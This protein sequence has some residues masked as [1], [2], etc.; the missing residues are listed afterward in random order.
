[1]SGC[2]ALDLLPRNDDELI[3]RVARAPLPEPAEEAG[4]LPRG[5]VARVR[6]L[7]NRVPAEAVERPD[8]TTEVRRARL[9]RP[10]ELGSI[11]NTVHAVARIAGTDFPLT[12][13]TFL[14]LRRRYRGHPPS[15]CS[16]ARPAETGGDRG[17]RGACP[18]PTRCRAD[19]TRHLADR[20]RRDD[21]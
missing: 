18:R 14:K 4:A 15:S 1:V 21:K 8:R 12:V 11:P 3:R 2:P 17:R 6:G 19:H 5:L 20:A 16:P 10:A 13:R 7:G 9:A